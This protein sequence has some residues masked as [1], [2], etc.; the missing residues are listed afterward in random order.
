MH[1]DYSTALEGRRCKGLVTTGGSEK[2]TFHLSISPPAR[3]RLASILALISLLHKCLELGLRDVAEDLK[4]KATQCVSDAKRDVIT[5]K[6]LLTS[7]TEVAGNVAAAMSVLSTGEGQADYK[8]VQNLMVLADDLEKA[9]DGLVLPSIAE[10]SD[11]PLNTLTCKLK[12]SNSLLRAALG[13]TAER[14]VSGGAD[15]AAAGDGEA[16]GTD[17]VESVSNG[18][19]IEIPKLN[20]TEVADSVNPKVTVAPRVAAPKMTWASLQM[21]TPAVRFKD[22]LSEQS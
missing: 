15:T 12:V 1:Y 5:V 13:D 8:L 14:G 7:A 4:V 11:K 18:K 17:T 20:S 10:S 22:I 21:A 6:I 2:C 16:L 3:L 9:C 19:G